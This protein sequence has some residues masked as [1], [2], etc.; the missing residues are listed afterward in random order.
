MEEKDF[1]VDKYGIVVEC[2][3]DN[4]QNKL[5]DYKSTVDTERKLSYMA[6]AFNDFLKDIKKK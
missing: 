1:M 2:A 6:K 3:Y 4:L 5:D